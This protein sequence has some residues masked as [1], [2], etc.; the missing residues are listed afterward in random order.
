MCLGTAAVGVRC[1]YSL[2]IG[3]PDH[4][5]PGPA[6][7]GTACLPQLHEWKLSLCRLVLHVLGA[8]A[9]RAQKAKQVFTAA[10]SYRQRGDPG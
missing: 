4:Q 3:Q 6:C 1:I 7:M 9:G 2:E 8:K 5:M 10:P